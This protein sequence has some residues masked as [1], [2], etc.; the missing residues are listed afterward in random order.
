MLFESASALLETPHG[1]AEQT[2]SAGYANLVALHY[3]RATGV[4][5]AAL[6]DRALKNI[7]LALSNL[8]AFEKTGGGIGYWTTSSDA[9]ISVTAYALNFLIDAAPVVSVDEDEIHSFAAWLEKQQNPDGRWLIVDRYRHPTEQQT[10]LLTGLAIRSLAAAQK[11]GVKV[12]SSVFATAYHHIALFTDQLDEPYMLAQFILAALDSGDEKLLGNAVPRLIAMARPERDGF[13]WDLRTNSPFYGWG[14]A[15]RYETTGLAISALTAWKTAHPGSADATT[16]IRKGLLFLLRSRDSAGIW[17]TTQSTVLAMRALADASPILGNPVGSG[18]AIQIL[19]NGAQVKTVEMPP[20]GKSAD[21]V[22]VD[23]SSFLRSGDNNLEL[24]PSPG[25]QSALMHL[26][27]SY[28]TP[29]D[30]K[31]PEKPGELSLSVKYDRVQ[32]VVGD[33]IHCTVNAERVGFRGYGMML[34]EVGLPPATEVDR[35]SLETALGD[36]AAGLDR[37]DVLPDRVILYL[38]PVAGG[39]KLDFIVR[40]RTSMAAKTAPSVLYDYYNPEARSE[41]VPAQLTVR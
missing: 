36:Y 39:A 35:S 10:L 8:P 38:W 12:P 23:I 20:A 32:A 18:G 19:A 6:E 22:I 28:W 5:S 24:L 4:A 7:R 1:C 17:Q 9:D 40:P 34:A 25:T 26:T 21:P 41:V 14:T 2:I 16:A 11:S 33:A 13:Y 37:Y 3:A 29:W 15:G 27:S 31:A 30:Q